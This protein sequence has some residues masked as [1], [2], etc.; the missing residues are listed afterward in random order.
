MHTLYIDLSDS[1]LPFKIGRPNKPYSEW[2]TTIFTA[3]INTEGS[4]SECQPYPPSLE[5]HVLK[6]PFDL[7]PV[8]LY[9]STLQ[10]VCTYLQD[11]YPE[12]FI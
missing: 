3:F 11:H 5:I 2:C 8:D 12:V 9:K 6:V 10:E 7:V 1:F 4:P